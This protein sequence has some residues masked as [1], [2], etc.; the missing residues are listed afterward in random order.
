MVEDSFVHIQE[1]ARQSFI[2]IGWPNKRKEGWDY[3]NL[4]YLFKNKTV[5]NSPI[6]AMR[7]EAEKEKVFEA[8][9]PIKLYF[10]N[11]NCQNLSVLSDIDEIKVHTI[12]KRDFL[13]EG[14]DPLLIANLAYRK[15][16]LILEVNNNLSRPLQ[17]V[18]SCDTK[19]EE[20]AF[21][22]VVLDIKPFVKMTLIEQHCGEGTLQLLNEINISDKAQLT[23]IKLHQASNNQN[24]VVLTRINLAKE[25]QLKSVIVCCHDSL[26]N[27]TQNFLSRHELRVV[28][29]GIEARAK[30]SA[31]LLGDKKAHLDLRIVLEHQKPCTYSDTIIHSALAGHAT[32]VFQGKVIVH[33]D[34]QKVEANQNIKSILLSP[35]AQMNT[36]PELEIYADDVLCA[37]GSAIG[38]IDED[39]LFYLRSRGI[40]ESQALHIILK[41]FLKQS[42]EGMEETL[43]TALEQCLDWHLGETKGECCV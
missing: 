3:T 6:S 27:D 34:A 42:F 30:L 35:H 23:Y 33:P 20:I 14:D 21:G 11:G 40:P 22:Y 43:V 29:A 4:A 7:I 26:Q 41:G 38:D 25:S 5:T 39:I 15:T 9:E 8:L 12:D 13:D 18:W 16:N 1:K 24:A 28:F 36:K 10:H 17:F 19:E 31:V 32:G 37:H 2:E